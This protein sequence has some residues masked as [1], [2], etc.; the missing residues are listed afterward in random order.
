MASG[1][2]RTMTISARAILAFLQVALSNQDL[3]EVV[4][5]R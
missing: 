1:S 4:Q 3:E 5:P 2:E